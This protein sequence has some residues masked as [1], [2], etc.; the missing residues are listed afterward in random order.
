LKAGSDDEKLNAK[1]LLAAL[2]GGD[3]SMKRGIS[4]D[5]DNMRG[6][7]AKVGVR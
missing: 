4:G 2:K 3:K 1:K 7:R 6:K 5:E